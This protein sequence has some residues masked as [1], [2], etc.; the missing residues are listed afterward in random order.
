MFEQTTIES[1]NCLQDL[2]EWTQVHF[3]YHKNAILASKWCLFTIY[4]NFDH[5]CDIW[6][7]QWP[8]IDPSDQSAIQTSAF[9]IDRKNSHKI[10]C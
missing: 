2:Q 8:V 6:H 5:F 3:A 7:D 9:C 10:Y 4:D 1:N